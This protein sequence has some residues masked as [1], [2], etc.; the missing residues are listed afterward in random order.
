LKRNSLVI[1]IV[2]AALVLMAWS[3]YQNLK[4]RRMEQQQRAQGVT[5][6]DASNQTV[7]QDVASDEGLPNLRGK[8]APGFTLRN[9][10]G[11]KVSLAD[12]KGKAVLINFWATW[13]PPCKLEMPWIVELRKQY[14]AQGFE[15]LGIDEDDAKDKG[16]VLKFVAKTGVNYPVLMGDD[17]VSK[18]YGG[19]EFLPTSYYMGRDGKIVEETAGLA[20]RDE[21]E[22][23]IKKAI[24][25]KA[26]Q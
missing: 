10:E 7:G 25:T 4:R 2:L 19:V 18:A 6:P 22:A 15:V 17:A 1:L 21:I 5:V 8:K 16:A 23:N 9:L 3:G 20:S 24:A 11:K 13:C 26:G 14:A 12:Y